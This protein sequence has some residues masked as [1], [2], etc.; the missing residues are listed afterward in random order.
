MLAEVALEIDDVII[1]ECILASKVN[2][3]HKRVSSHGLLH[4]SKHLV[5]PMLGIARALS[6]VYLKDDD[7]EEVDGP[8]QDQ[9]VGGQP[10]LPYEAVKHE[11]I[12]DEKNHVAEVLRVKAL[13]L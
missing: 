8:V 4:M 9:E 5:C 3:S 7:H 1:V 12:G 10:S 2:M 11:A 6:L 13:T